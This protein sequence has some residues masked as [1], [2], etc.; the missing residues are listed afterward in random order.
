MVSGRNLQIMFDA[1][2]KGVLWGKKP[3]GQ[4]CLVSSNGT[5]KHDA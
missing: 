5:E 1:N 3:F 4:V 2:R